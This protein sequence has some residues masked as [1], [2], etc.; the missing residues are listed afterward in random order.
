M[1]ILYLMLLLSGLKERKNNIHNVNLSVSTSKK[2]FFLPIAI[3]SFDV[4]NESFLG[5]QHH[6][7]FCFSLSSAFPNHLLKLRF[8]ICLPAKFENQLSS[9]LSAR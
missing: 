8:R 6:L 3:D 2:K 5:H 9:N 4:N 1:I 7:S